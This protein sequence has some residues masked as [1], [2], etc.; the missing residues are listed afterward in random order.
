MAALE[1]WTRETLKS[2]LDDFFSLDDG[3]K[4]VVQE[5]SQCLMDAKDD[6]ADHEEALDCVHEVLHVLH[7]LSH[8]RGQLVTCADSKIEELIVYY[9]EELAPMATKTGFG[10][11]YQYF[12]DE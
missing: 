11:F 5:T 6:H 10:G 8:F 2:H 4:A 12:S 7:E 1:L 9:E 3:Y